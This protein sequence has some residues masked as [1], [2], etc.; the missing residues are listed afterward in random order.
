MR[1]GIVSIRGVKG[2]AVY[3]RHQN[4]A[5]CNAFMKEHGMIRTSWDWRSETKRGEIWLD[6]STRKWTA[7]WWFRP[8]KVEL[9][10]Q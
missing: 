1:F 7:C 10:G 5:E 4:R 8:R 6:Y 3:F 2:S 9:I